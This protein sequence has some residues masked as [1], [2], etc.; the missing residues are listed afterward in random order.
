MKVVHS[1][2]DWGEADK[3]PDYYARYELADFGIIMS[4]HESP[5]TSVDSQEEREDNGDVGHDDT[6][7]DEETR[8]A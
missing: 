4:K 1:P 7:D 5:D 8:E 2:R 3:P 6:G